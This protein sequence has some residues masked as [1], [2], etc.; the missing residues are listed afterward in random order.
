MKYYVEENIPQRS[1]TTIRH[2]IKLMA[3]ISETLIFFYLGVVTITTDHEWNWA[4][5]LF[6]LV[7]AFV[8]RGIGERGRL[9]KD[10]LL[11]NPFIKQSNKLIFFIA[12]ILVLTQ[13]I[14][15]FRTIHFTYKD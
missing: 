11:M 7:I 14:N 8:W 15:P 12:G 13:I 1:C 4:H 9:C 3:T 2:V 10:L 5:I 6:T